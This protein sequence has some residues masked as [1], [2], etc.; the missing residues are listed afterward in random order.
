VAAPVIAELQKQINAQRQPAAQQIN[1]PRPA[2]V[3]ALE[4]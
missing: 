3:E 2:P 1:A 4:G